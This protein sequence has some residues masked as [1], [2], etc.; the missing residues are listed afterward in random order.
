[1]SIYRVST[2]IDDFMM[3]TIDD[4]DVYEKMEDFDIDGF[5]K[6]LEFNWEAPRARFIK[7]DSGSQLAPDLC[8]WNGSDL[9]ISSNT[10]Q[11]L[12]ELIENLG[13]FLPLNGKCKKYWLFNPINKLGN[14][15][16]NL[17][18][19]K[20]S[21]FDDGSWDRLERLVFR[22]SALEKLP[23]IF[24]LEIDR[25]IA[26][27]VTDR[28]KAEVSEHNFTGLNFEVIQSA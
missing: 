20:L 7:S 28:F 23:A 1:M 27:Y 3:F 5:G 15:V 24:T 8:Q 22:V 13:E 21:Y 26:I 11:A 16:I 17:E 6:K 25:G 10:R 18:Q 9:V 4:L 14:D 19:T 12:F 2:N